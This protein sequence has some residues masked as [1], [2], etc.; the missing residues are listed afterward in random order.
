MFRSSSSVGA[1]SA[2]PPSSPSGTSATTAGDRRSTTVST[3]CQFAM[4]LV[5]STTVTQVSRV[6]TSERL[7]TPAALESK[8]KVSATCIGSETPVDSITCSCTTGSDE[9]HKVFVGRVTDQVVKLPSPCQ[10]SDL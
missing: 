1:T 10:S 6:A 8:V 4:K 9:G 2:G 3:E 7:A 5:V